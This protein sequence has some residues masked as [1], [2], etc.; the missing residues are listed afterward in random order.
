MV[1]ILSL[2]FRRDFGLADQ[3]SLDG[4]KGIVEGVKSAMVVV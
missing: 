1:A 4:R 2:G 3:S